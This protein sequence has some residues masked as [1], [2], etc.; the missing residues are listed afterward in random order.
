MRHLDYVCFQ[1][2][3]GYA[4]AA[5]DYIYALRGLN[6]YHL[7]VSLLHQGP[8]QLAITRERYS[9][10]MAM[11]RSDCAA[12]ATQI[13]H[14]IPD[15]QRHVQIRGK[16]VGFATFETY[17]PPEHWVE[18]LNMNDAVICPSRFNVEVFQRAGVKVPIHYVPH[19]YDPA[20]FNTAPQKVERSDKFTF[21]FFGTWKRRKGWPE[22]IE[23]WYRE[24]SPDD[25]VELLI[26]TD[27][28]S[29]SQKCI[30]EMK[31]TLGLT[32]KE[33]APIKWETRVL[34]DRELPLLFKRADCLISP[35]LGEGFGLPG[36]Q[37]MACGLPVIVTN[38]AGP[39]DYAS[40]ETATLI[41]PVKHIVYSDMD[42]IPQFR[43]KKWANVTVEGVR[44]SMRYALDNVDKLKEKAVFAA[45][46][47]KEYAYEPVAHRFETLLEQI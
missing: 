20:L 3:S 11:I 26:K 23:A 7:H 31:D 41:Q 5:L 38:F 18:I 28:L 29:L 27:R 44:S 42:A 43:N 8:D 30:T 17:D 40:E 32:R 36:L 37:S 45:E 47:V 24:F 34:N 2:R 22:L 12:D 10:L 13:L 25:N 21:L 14:C 9:E 1:N 39:T 16:S 6:K 19:C 46:K 35:S 15:K 33:T 4:Q